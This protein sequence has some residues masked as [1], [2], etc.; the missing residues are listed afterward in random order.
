MSVLQLENLRYYYD[1]KR[2][3]LE[4]INQSFEKGKIYAIIGPSGCGKSTLLSLLGGLDVPKEGRILFDGI[5]IT[6]KGLENHRR[7]HISFVFQQ[8]NLIEYMTPEEN[9]K[10]TASKEPMLTL[11]QVGLTEEEAK[12]NVLKLSGGQQQRVAIARALAS[13]NAVILTDEPTGNLDEQTESQIIEIL[14]EAAREYNKCVIIV[15]HAHEV[16]ESADTVLLLKNG[17]LRK[18]NTFG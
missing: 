18:E 5:D 4:N 6:K 8:Y 12:R 3:I 17:M 15:S 11:K 2:I 1:T 7:H 13:D 9:V 16:A 14:K 10:L